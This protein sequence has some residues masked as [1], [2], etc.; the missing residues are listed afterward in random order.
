MKQRISLLAM[1][2]LAA[3]ATGGVGAAGSNG[4]EP[5]TTH[6]VVPGDGAEIDQAGRRIQV[7]CTRIGARKVA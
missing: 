2:V 1:L 6:R 3:A 5:D 7:L 4:A